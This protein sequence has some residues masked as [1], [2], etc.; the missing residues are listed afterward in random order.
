MKKLLKLVFGRA[1]IILIIFAIQMLFLYEVFYVMSEYISYFIG[2]F[3]IISVFTIVYIINSPTNPNFKLAWIVPIVLV[4]V[5][6]TLFY[7]YV[8][9]GIG[10]RLMKSNLREIFAQTN[11]LLKQDEDVREEIKYKAPDVYR[12]SSYTMN[13]S[14]FPIY[15]NTDAKYFPLGE[16]GFEEMVKQLKKAEKFIFLEYF[17]IEKGEMLST[18]ENILEEKVKQG[19][20]V[21]FMY[22][23]LVSLSQMPYNYPKL[24]QIKGIRAKQYLPI[25]P[26]MSTSYNNR[27]HRKILVIDGK[28]AF[29]GGINIGDEYINKKIRFGHWKDNVI[30]I[31]GDAVKSFTLMFLQMWNIGETEIEEYEKYM[32]V[33]RQRATSDGYMIPYGDSPL[34]NTQMGENIYLDIIANS[35][36]YVHIMTPYLVLDD[37]MVS[38]LIFA[39]KS[40]VDVKIIMPHIPDKWY[41]YTLARTYYR[42]LI[43]YGVKIYEYIPGFVHSKVFLSDDSKATVG[44][45]NLDYRSLYLH[46][47]C[48]V[49]LYGG[50]VINDIKEDFSETLKKCKRITVEEAEE[51]NFFKRIVGRFVLRIFAPL[52]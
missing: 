9:T 35:R 29:T 25:K 26:I 51:S 33:E 6:G 18:I 11:H 5:F 4:P 1:T 10:T 14:N 41:V 37:S 28:A 40:G 32:N 17:I 7:I 2:G 27:D 13:T 46:F 21:R 22:D 42:E 39:A 47:E 44:T 49:Y 16:L 50:S 38:S 19:V 12:L 15:K 30:M 52:L 8:Q 23:G 3:T 34:D 43:K 20:E 24:L 31:E 45:V 48:G 36:D